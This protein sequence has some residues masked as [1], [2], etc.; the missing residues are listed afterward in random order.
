MRRTRPLR[1]SRGRLWDEGLVTRTDCRGRGS[2]V[3]EMGQRERDSLKG[4]RQ[5]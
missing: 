4:S 3:P 1:G 5:G 2:S